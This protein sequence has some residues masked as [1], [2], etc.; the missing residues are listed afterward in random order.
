MRRSILLAVALAALA[1]LPAAAW[2]QR[3]QAIL[4]EAG[5]DQTVGIVQ[6]DAQR[7]L[8][9]VSASPDRAA[10]LHKL[11]GDVNA[12]DVLHLDVPPPAG[13]PRFADTT[14]PVPRSDPRFPDALR[15]HLERYYDVTLR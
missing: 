10:W 8:S 14:A 9:V 15:Q 4:H 1:S 3:F 7:H 2:A 13:S 5:H 11:V 6:L 12:E